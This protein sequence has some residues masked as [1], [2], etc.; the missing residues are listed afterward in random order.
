MLAELCL[1]ATPVQ[2]A[3]LWPGVHASEEAIKLCFEELLRDPG[4]DTAELRERR[5]ARAAVAL[6][7]LGRGELAWPLLHASRDNGTRSFLIHDLAPC[8]VQPSLLGAPI[9]RGDRRVREAVAAAGA[10]RDESTQHFPSAASGLRRK[11]ARRLP[12]RCRRGPARRQRLA[13]AGA[14]IMARRWPKSIANCTAVRLPRGPHPGW[15]VNRE[16]ITLVRIPAPAEFRIGSPPGEMGRESDEAQH[17]A[18]IERPF[19][20]AST[21][22][23]LRQFLPRSQNSPPKCNFKGSS[24]PP[25]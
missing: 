12:Q 18:R 5:R 13:A 10:G 4:G 7:R 16:G 9:R 3:N 20:I 23:T 15:F 19:A 6:L 17:L 21:E 2:L 1:E 14:G 8:R 11:V 22:V 24:T 25:S